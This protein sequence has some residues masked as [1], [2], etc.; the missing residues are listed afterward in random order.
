MAD[1]I[2]RE[3]TEADR[4]AIDAI[5]TE[6]W[7]RPYIAVG[8]RG[9][10]LTGQPALVALLGDEVVGVLVY[11]VDG[12]ALE[13]LTINSRAGGAGTGMITAARDHAVS[14]GLRR[15][16]LVTTNNNSQALRFYQRN[17]LHLVAVR[18]GAVAASRKAK[19]GIAL[20]DADGHAISDE[21]V[22]EMRLDGVEN[23]YD[24]PGQAAAVALTRLLSWQGGE[25]DLWPLLADPRATVDVVRGLARPF[26]GTVDVVL[27]PDPGGVLF[28][29]LVARELE[30]PFAP[31]CRDRR[32]FFKGP[33]E[34]ASAQAGAD[35]LHAHRAALSDG[36][37]V[38]LVD[39]WSETG[40]TVRG[41]AEL[42]AGTGAELVGVS[43]LVDSLRPEV[44]AGLEA[45]GIEVRGLVAVD[46]F[47]RR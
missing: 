36:A 24:E 20:T 39:D 27:G 37:R 10:V 13:V 18:T 46:E 5:L 42:V 9:V 40:S 3:A 21:L 30:V 26:M 25:T 23:P 31:V 47:T 7:G 14:L 1:T 45:Q 16:W 44:R 28:G 4:P 11:R 15:L 41:V 8:G 29:P 43:Y 34:R 6:S 2:I 19:P 38:L 32:F 22:L 12:D 33:H 35:E 17:G